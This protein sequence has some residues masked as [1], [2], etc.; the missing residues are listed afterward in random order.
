MP[1]LVLSAVTAELR[2]HGTRFQPSLI[3]SY[4]SRTCRPSRSAPKKLVVCSSLDSVR[5]VSQTHLSQ[6]GMC[7]GFASCEAFDTQVRMQ[8]LLATHQC[9]DKPQRFQ[10]LTARWR[11][12]ISNCRCV[13]KTELQLP[14]QLSYGI[15]ASRAAFLALE[16]AFRLFRS[17]EPKFKSSMCEKQSA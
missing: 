15:A 3:G 2:R 7:F 1:N 16:S 12:P 5:Q 4:E 10:V 9:P 17:C 11:C 6:L 8:P 13:E 14:E